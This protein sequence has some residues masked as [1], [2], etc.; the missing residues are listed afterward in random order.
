MARINKK[1][2]KKP[3]K[4]EKVVFLLVRIKEESKKANYF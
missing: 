1:D 2:V 3:V 4:Q